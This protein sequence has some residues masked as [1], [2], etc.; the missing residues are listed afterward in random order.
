MFLVLS[1]VARVERHTMWIGAACSD[2][3]LRAEK[4]LLLHSNLLSA[5]PR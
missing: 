2:Q 3:L 1:A 4:P 5:Y